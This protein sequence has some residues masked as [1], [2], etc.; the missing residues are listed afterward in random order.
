MEE[1][2]KAAPPRFE[3]TIEVEGE[4]PQGVLDRQLRGVP[5]DCGPAGGPPTE[6]DSRAVR[7]HVSPYADFIPL[8]KK[9]GGLLKKKP[10]EKYFLYRVRRPDG[11]TYAVRTERV[12]DAWLVVAPGGTAYE[13][14]EA[15][16]SM[17]DATRAL[18]RLEQGFA[19]TA[20]SAPDGSPQPWATQQPCTPK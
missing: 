16:G 20:R 11:V 3:E 5:L 12:P 18:R 6:A 10:K 13:F 15:F 1:E 9:L 4:T 7:P 8:A 14:I 17:G 2:A 19:R